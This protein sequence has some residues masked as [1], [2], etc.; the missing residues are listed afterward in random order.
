MRF[1]RNENHC[2]MVALHAVWYNFVKGRK[3]KRPI[4]RK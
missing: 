1:P 3:T 4:A 2:Y